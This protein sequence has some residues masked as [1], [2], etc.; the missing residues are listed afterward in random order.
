[1]LNYRLEHICSYTATLAPTE[2]I[3][4]VPEG[5]RVNAYVTGGELTGPRLSGKLRPVGGDW[6][7]LRT[8]GVA[9]LD[10]RATF[11]THDGALIYTAY[12]GLLEFGPD[13]YQDFLQ[14]KLT[15]AYPIRI[16]PR[17]QT[18]HPAYLWLTR[19]Q[20]VGIGE[21]NMAEGK[22]QYDILALY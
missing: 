12:S 2:V 1:M 17:Y 19:L 6:V 15:G 21:V 14:G 16:A 10:V 7:L 9:I 13:G 22:V 8:D 4:I 11:E 3:G 5:I 18:S 20:C